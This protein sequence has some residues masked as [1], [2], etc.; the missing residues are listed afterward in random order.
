LLTRIRPHSVQVFWRNG[1][2]PSVDEVFYSFL[3]GSSLPN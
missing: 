1:H 2:T 3:G